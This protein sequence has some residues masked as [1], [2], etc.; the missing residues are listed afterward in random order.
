M[1]EL[2][3]L[4]KKHNSDK[5]S[6]WHNYSPMYFE[7]FKNLRDKEVN[8][9]ELGILFGGSVRAWGEFFRNGKIYAGDFDISTFV[10]ENNIKSYYCDQDNISSIFSLWQNLDLKNVQFDLIIDDGKHEFVSNLNF[11][12]NSFHKLKEN[13][14]YIIEDLTA[15]TVA[16]FNSVKEYL[17]NKLNIDFVIVDIPYE[18][19]QIDNRI[20]LIKK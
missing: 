6:D 9:F 10:D 18:P 19:N 3:E 16:G 4:F 13:G 15:S 8:V 5:C 2:C 11:L 12:E 14:V 7:M 17:K 20:L 1:T